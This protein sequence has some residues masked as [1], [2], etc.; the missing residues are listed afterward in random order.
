LAEVQDERLNQA[1]NSLEGYPELDPSV[2]D[3]QYGLLNCY[4]LDF[5]YYRGMA[6]HFR[7]EAEHSLR[8]FTGQ[9]ESMMK[10]GYPLP[11]IDLDRLPEFIKSSVQPADAME[12]DGN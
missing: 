1:L 5:V 12:T 4:R 11:Q 10:K 3:I 6:K 8:L 9:H 7:D 2:E